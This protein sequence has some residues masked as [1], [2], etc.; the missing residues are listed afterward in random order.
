MP[1]ALTVPV[2]MVTSR[3]QIRWAEAWPAVDKTKVGND[4][5]EQIG[6]EFDKQV[7]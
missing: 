6:S 3:K 7:F 5:M 4:K 2:A 1:T